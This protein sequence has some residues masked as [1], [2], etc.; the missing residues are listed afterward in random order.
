MNDTP[1][2]F[3]EQGFSILNIFLRNQKCIIVHVFILFLMTKY[4][5]ERNTH[6]NTRE[7]KLTL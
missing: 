1:R 6:M 5:N 7:R 3:C 2:K 4:Y